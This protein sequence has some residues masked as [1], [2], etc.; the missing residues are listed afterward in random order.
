MEVKYFIQISEKLF[1][2]IDVEIMLNILNEGLQEKNDAS[3]K[4]K[5]KI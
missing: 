4:K 1:L 3:L 5:K 2:H